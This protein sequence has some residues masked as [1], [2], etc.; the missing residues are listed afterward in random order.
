RAALEAAAG[1]IP[2]VMPAAAWFE[3]GAAVNDLASP[4]ACACATT[5]AAGTARTAPGGKTPADAAKLAPAATADTAAVPG[6]GTLAVSGKAANFWP[7]VGP[8]LVSDIS[9]ILLD[10]PLI[11]LSQGNS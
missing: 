5:P 6:P 9:S 3:D 4:A 8:F 2:G 11:H 10:R 7:M 1:L